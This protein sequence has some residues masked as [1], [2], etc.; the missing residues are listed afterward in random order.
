PE[1]INPGMEA[2]GVMSWRNIGDAP[3]LFDLVLYLVSPVGARYGPLQVN[4]DLSANPQVPATQNLRLGT[5][6]IPSGIYSVVAEIY[7]STT[8]ALLAAQTLP[9]RLQIREIAPPVVPVIPLPVVPEVPTIDILGTPSLNLPSQLNVGDV[10]S[11]SVSLPT[12]GTVPYFVE[13]RLLLRD[14]TGFEY[15]V[16]QGG[17]TLYSGEPLQVPVNY[18]TS[19]FAGG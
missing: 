14:P 10:W 16:A 2:T 7:D 12:F 9:G 11:G 13:T 5:V 3:Q 4:Q 6:G 15:I 19:G 1:E 18:N 17:R 8:G